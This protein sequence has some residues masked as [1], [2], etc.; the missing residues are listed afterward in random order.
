MNNLA[1]KF[2]LCIATIFSLSLLQTQELWAQSRSLPQSRFN[3]YSGNGQLPSSSGL[4][5]QEGQERPRGVPAGVYNPGE[6][7]LN[8]KLVRWESRFMPLKVWVS[9]GKRLQDEPISVINAQRPQELLQA[10]KSD[11]SLNSLAQ[12]PGWDEEMN[13]AAKAGIEQWKEFQNEGLFSFVFVDDPAL[14]NIFLFWTPRFTGDEGVGGVSTGGNT[15]AVLYDAAEVHRREAAINQ[16]LQGT[17][18]IMELQVTADSYEKLQARVA[19]EFG[20]ALGIKEHSP[21]NEDLMCVN[22]IAKYLSAS[23]K[24]TIRWLYHQ[25]PQFVMLPPV[26]PKFS[27]P[28]PS[29]QAAAASSG[30]TNNTEADQGTANR[31]G[32]GYRVHFNRPTPDTD[33]G[34]EGSTSSISGSSTYKTGSQADLDSDSSKRHPVEDESDTKKNKEKKSKH[35]KDD[36]EPTAGSSKNGP[37]N[38]MPTLSSPPAQTRPKASEGY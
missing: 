8:Y 16:P 10:L 35:R 1:P 20:H 32:G 15:V 9:P 38:S 3:N 26:L 17:P 6:P 22:G 18:V 30:G 36:D 13:A 29:E 11:P 21:F 14:A 31:P 33:A 4:R 34:T 7:K 24:A 5:L 19:H 28:A 37:A 12:C 25:Q 2:L 27:A 23:D